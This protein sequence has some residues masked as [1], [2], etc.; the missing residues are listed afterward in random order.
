[1]LLRLLKSK[2][3]MAAVT[4][5]ELHYHGSIT[6]DR[7]IMDAV[8]LLPYEQV[9]IANCA[10]GLRGETYVIEGGRGS[11]QIQMNGALARMAHS[12]DRIIVLAFAFATPEEV[13]HHHP[14]VAIL[15]EHNRIV[16][17]FDAEI[18]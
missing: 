8:G 17:K 18:V 9:L 12:G 4:K 6:I 16:E 13:P 11:G 7:D 15:D 1:M 14:Q 2:L 3:H 5:T 10:N